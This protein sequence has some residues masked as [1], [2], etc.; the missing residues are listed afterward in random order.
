MIH[1]ARTKT[2]FKKL[3]R[4]LREALG[5]A[6]P[7]DVETIAIG[8]LERLWHAT[9]TDAFRGDIG[10]LANDE[11]AESIGWHGNADLIVSILVESRWIDK[12]DEC[13][14][15]VHDWAEHAPRWVQGN[16]AKYGG[17]IVPVGGSLEEAPIGG[18][19]KE[20]PPSLAKPSLTKPNQTKPSLAKPVGDACELAGGF[21]FLR[22]AGER[23]SDVKRFATALGKA[24]GNV[25]TPDDRWEIAW[26]GL[27]CREGFIP[28]IIEKFKRL[29]GTE[30]AV[31]HPKRW[32]LG[33]LK[34]ELSE[35]D[36]ALDFAQE[37]VRANTQK[38]DTPV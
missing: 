31:N 30:N 14:L 9:A 28:E 19:L 27:A 25:L 3:L 18:S 36:V 32:L 24:F 12:H 20:S 34:K 7:I 23:N 13:R 33:S 16:A 4:L 26:I 37:F 17:F 8:L 11:I 5:A 29:Q 21:E 2:K 15:V 22:L 6:V 38:G 1:T 10:K 35:I